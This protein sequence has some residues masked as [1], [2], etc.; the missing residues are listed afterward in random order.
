MTYEENIKQ[1]AQEITKWPAWK[2]ANMLNV[3]S[4][5]HIRVPNKK[6]VILDFDDNILEV[7]NYEATAKAKLKILD[8]PSLHIQEMYL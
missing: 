8:D 7:F 2:I 3:F 5:K 4:E 6:W 1:A